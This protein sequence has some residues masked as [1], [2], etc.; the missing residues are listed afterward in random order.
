MH[1]LAYFL[2]SLVCLPLH[3]KLRMGVQLSEKYY[4]TED[5]WVGLDFPYDDYRHHFDVSVGGEVRRSLDKF[6]SPRDFI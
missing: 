6:V 1:V 5:E 4:L 2:C 3:R